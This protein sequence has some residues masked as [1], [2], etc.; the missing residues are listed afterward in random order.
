MSVYR[1]TTKGNKRTLEKVDLEAMREHILEEY[2]YKTAKVIAKQ[3]NIPVSTLRSYI[4]RWRKHGLFEGKNIKS[5][6]LEE[7]KD[8]I[9]ELHVDECVL[10]THLA[11]K[12]DV[13]QPMMVMKLKEW[14]VYWTRRNRVVESKDEVIRL[15][16]E[17]LNM[18][19]IARRLQVDR[20]AIG[21]WLRRWQQEGLV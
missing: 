20:S 21:H 6:K 4:N 5:Q 13:S 18:T 7:D 16:R 1:Q 9:I 8:L 17:G 19:Q 12:F 2:E 11:E 15:A 10:A 3:L 14:G